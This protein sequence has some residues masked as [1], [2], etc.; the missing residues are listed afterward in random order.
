MKCL[1]KCIYLWYS[2]F[3]PLLVTVFIGVIQVSDKIISLH[4][5]CITCDNGQIKSVLLFI[6]TFVSLFFFNDQ[7]ITSMMLI[8]LVY[9][10]T[11]YLESCNRRSYLNKWWTLGITVEKHVL[12]WRAETFSRYIVHKNVCVTVIFIYIT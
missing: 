8:S 10:W 1:N 5:V 12:C 7:N 6:H 3:T 4:P 2:F 9:N 11:S